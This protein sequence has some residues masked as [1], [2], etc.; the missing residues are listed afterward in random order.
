[1]F[2]NHERRMSYESDPEAWKGP[3]KCKVCGL[4]SDPETIKTHTRCFGFLAKINGKWRKI[5]AHTI[6]EAVGRSKELL[7]S[8]LKFPDGAVMDL[9]DDT[10]KF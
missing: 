2:F 3:T 8:H 1:M 4:L 7:A 6:G 5:K 10:I 9:K